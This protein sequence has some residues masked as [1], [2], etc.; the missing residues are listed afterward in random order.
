M[1]L[2]TEAAADIRYNH[3]D[4]LQS[5]RLT[6]AV[7]NNLRHLSCDP[8]GHSFAGRIVGCNDDE[9]LQRC[10]AVTMNFEIFFNESIGGLKGAV[11]IAVLKRAVPGQ[12][13][14]QF[15]EQ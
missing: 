6:Q 15:F 10:R 12:I 5:E 11:D 3:A 1:N 7:V 4:V 2:L 14:A 8:D 13:A 9:R